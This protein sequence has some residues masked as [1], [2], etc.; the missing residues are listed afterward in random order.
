MY[1]HFS[2]AADAS[3][4]PVILYNVPGRTAVDCWPGT[5]ARLARNPAHCGLKEATAA[6]SARAEILSQCPQE[7]ILLSGDDATAMDFMRWG[8]AASFR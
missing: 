1:R 4:T 6:A 8:R 7:F 3:D 2:A 5:V